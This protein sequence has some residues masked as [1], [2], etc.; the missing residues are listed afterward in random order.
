M[1]YTFSDKTVLLLRGE[2]YID[3]SPRPKKLTN[4]GVTSNTFGRFENKGYYIISSDWMV[5]DK[6]AEFDFGKDDFTIDWWE[7]AT[8]NYTGSV[9][10]TITNNNGFYFGRGAS[11]KV[12]YWVSPTN[13]P[14]PNFPA[15]DMGNIK[16]KQWVHRAIV[17]DKN[18]IRT[19]ENGVQTS[20]VDYGD[21]IVYYG[22]QQMYFG[23]H[24]SA[25]IS[26]YIDE[27]RIT[28]EAVWKGNFEVPTREYIGVS[29]NYSNNG[30]NY[31]FNI[32][33]VTSDY[34][35][36]K[37]KI[38]FNGGG[39]KEI[40]SGFE[41]FIYNLPTELKGIGDSKL[42]LII[43]YNTDQ[44]FTKVYNIENDIEPLPETPDLN[45]T[46]NAIN[47]INGNTDKQISIM[48]D[49]MGNNG[50]DIVDV[51]SMGALI[52]M[53]GDNK[54]AQHQTGVAKM[55]TD[56]DT[57]QLY[58][59]TSTVGTRLLSIHGLTFEPDMIVCYLK[60]KVTG[61]YYPNF[62]LYIKAFDMILSGQGRTDSTSSTYQ[63]CT[64]FKSNV[65][66][67]RVT[68]TEA[69]LPAQVYTVPTVNEIYVFHAFKF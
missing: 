34:T 9:F 52:D 56:T 27:F 43:T 50:F 11:G 15:K 13:A 37:V 63:R 30:D 59:T 28:K 48:K 66:P 26:C 14:D 18:F 62:I 19:Y 1:E 12:Q 7:F 2:D 58:G 61:T 47:L 42:K 22:D 3:K 24:S 39:V 64:P 16:L 44:E 45:S 38:T 40:T 51:N 36:N 67:A 53:L 23:R 69:I 4:S 20:E 21:N 65:A 55:S 29:I 68:N 35:I 54:L 25:Y 6:N 49:I 10:A 17:R 8:A 31:T 5:V 57:F 60:N 41:S 33:P 32:N 46:V